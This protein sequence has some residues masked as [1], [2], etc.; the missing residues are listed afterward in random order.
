MPG[1]RKTHEFSYGTPVPVILIQIAF[2]ITGIA[3]VFA[4]LSRGWRVELS[5]V[6]V[7]SLI[8]LGHAKL[9]RY[10]ERNG[11]AVP[12]PIRRVVVKYPTGWPRPMFAARLAFF[13]VVGLM[14]YFGVAPIAE[15]NAR[16]GITACVFALI[17]VAILNI[18]LERWYVRKGRAKEEEVGA[19]VK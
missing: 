2:P 19:R 12:I 10:Y 7:M 4:G 6:T 9:L 11:R 1:G 18:G 17:I 16:R 13:V 15:F 5:F 14:I 3:W 8:F